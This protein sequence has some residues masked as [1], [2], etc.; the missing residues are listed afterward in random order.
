METGG[1]V[2]SRLVGHGRTRTFRRPRQLGILPEKSCA[3]RS[4]HQRRPIRQQLGRLA[5]YVHQRRCTGYVFY[6]G[7]AQVGLRTIPLD[8]LTNWQ[9]EGGQTFDLR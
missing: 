7:N 3:A 9:T 5:P 4:R 6:T 2:P 8:K 1:C